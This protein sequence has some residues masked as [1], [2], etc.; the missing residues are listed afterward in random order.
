MA[1]CNGMVGADMEIITL[2]K[3]N[4]CG[5]KG[6]FISIM[7][8]MVIISMAL[9]TVLSVRDNCSKSYENALEQVQMICLKKQKI[10]QW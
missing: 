1:E 3:G 9:T 6:S 8:L 10:I 4:I 5:R 2:L 7:L